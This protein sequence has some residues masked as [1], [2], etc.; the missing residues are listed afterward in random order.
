MI[1]AWNKFR[2][3]GQQLAWEIGAALPDVID[4]D[5][6]PGLSADEKCARID[7]ARQVIHDRHELVRQTWLELSSSVS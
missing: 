3:E 2:D 7:E 6:W 1:D 4:A 5:A